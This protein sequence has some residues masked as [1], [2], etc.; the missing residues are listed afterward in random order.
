MEAITET[1]S[2]LKL[3]VP[4]NPQQVYEPASKYLDP[5]KKHLEENCSIPYVSIIVPVKLTHTALKKLKPVIFDR[6]R[7][8]NVF[9]VEGFPDRR[10]IVLKSCANNS[11]DDI[12]EHP[13]IQSFIDNSPPS[14]KGMFQR[15]VHLVR[16]SYK[17][18]NVEQVL[19]I[20]LPS[21]IEEIPSAFEV[22]GTLAHVNLREDCLPYR[23]II[24]QVILDKNQPRLKTIVNKVGSIVNEFRTFPME[25]I[26]GENN[27]EVEV[28]EEG[29]RFRLNFAEVY[30]NSRLQFE[31]RR[32]V[33]LIA[34]DPSVSKNK[35]LNKTTDGLKSTVVVA[36]LMCGVG[37]FA[38][39]LSFLHGIKVYANDL[40]PKSFKYLVE[41]KNLNAS[42]SKPKDLLQTY[43]MDGR[44]FVRY[45]ERENI[46]YH[47]VIM[48][49]PAIAIEFLD[50]FRGWHPPTAYPDHL[51]TI[52]VHC[53]VKYVTSEDMREKAIKR[54]E[55]ALGC[56]LDEGRDSVKIHVVRDVSPNKNMLCISFRLPEQVKSLARI[57]LDNCEG[58]QTESNS[59]KPRLE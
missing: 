6:P 57:S 27:T 19:R 17:D 51:P 12:Y 13:A 31:H 4:D 50:I 23:K 32:L 2:H 28:K 3:K 14:M 59:K 29:C 25:V 1:A 30:W 5:L 22:A 55:V 56:Q 53:F 11:E 34:K 44:A 20:L 21:D 10:K 7:T 54:C 24:G 47:H 46:L 43:N 8:R 48:N 38:I 26:A 41:N 35:E 42:K 39:P 15:S 18:I 49:L 40:N 36:D 58:E 9:S 45:L 37:P 16:T 33:N 52:H